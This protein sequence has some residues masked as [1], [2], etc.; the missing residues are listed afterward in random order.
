MV[1]LGKLPIDDIVKATIWRFLDDYI[2]HF[3]ITT[4]DGRS[5]FYTLAGEILRRKQ[6]ISHNHEKV[7]GVVNGTREFL[8]FARCVNLHRQ[9]IDPRGKHDVAFGS[10]DDGFRCNIKQVLQVGYYYVGCGDDKVR[11]Y[12]RQDLNRDP[13]I[14]SPKIVYSWEHPK[15]VFGIAAHAL[16]I[17]TACMDGLIRQYSLRTGDYVQ[18]LSC[19]Q[20]G[21]TGMLTVVAN[22]DFVISGGND[23]CLHVW[24]RSRN[25]ET[26]VL[27]G[28]NDWIT[29]LVLSPSR[30][31]VLS[32]GGTDQILKLWDY[33]YG[34]IL[35]SQS[36]NEEILKMCWGEIILIQNK[37]KIFIY[38]GAMTQSTNGSWKKLDECKKKLNFTVNIVDVSL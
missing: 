38:D 18:T 12:T 14:Y 24:N 8:T 5:R 1:H 30:P 26:F 10:G 23:R 35:W 31:F 25:V 4:D 7:F 33:N 9:E 37:K 27:P 6:R 36:W 19:V 16:D 34:T 28:H 22:S 29:S 17:F 20:E 11:V 13:S 3:V 32:S 15:N 2:A 21:G